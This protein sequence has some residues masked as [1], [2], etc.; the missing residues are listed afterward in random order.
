MLR[1]K[2]DLLLPLQSL[3]EW[4][5]LRLL[6]STLNGNYH[7]GVFHLRILIDILETVGTELGTHH[8][9][10]VHLRSVPCVQQKDVEIEND[11]MDSI[12]CIWK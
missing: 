4:Y 10:F 3:E 11:R 1:S 6:S 5:F 12:F 7:R 8:L 2:F 9:D